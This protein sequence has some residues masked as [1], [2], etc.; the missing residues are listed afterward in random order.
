MIVLR[1]RW[2]ILWVLLAVLP[3]ARATDDLT[4]LNQQL[5]VT[6][7]KPDGAYEI[8]RKEGDRPAIR[9]LVAAQ[10]NHHWVRSNEYPTHRVKQSDFHDALGHGE[11]LTVTLTGLANRPNLLYILRLYD[12]LPFGDIEVQVHNGT[13]KPV[14][15]EAIRSVEAFG[16][17]L[18]NLG[19]QEGS[20]R[21]LSD[22][23]S[24][25]SVQ[26]YDLGQAPRGMH[27]GVGSQLIY[28]RDSRQSL[29]FGA[30]TADRFLTVLR[31]QT[32][33]V[34]DKLRTTSYTIDSTGTTEARSHEGWFHRSPADARI[35]LSLPLAPG[36]SLASE[37]LMFALGSDYH[38]EV[39]SYGAA[40]RHLH[41]A[42]VTG[43]NPMGWWSWSAYYMTLD[44]GSVYTN[45]QWMAQHLRPLGY[46]FL[47]VDAG[48]QYSVS[49]FTTTNAAQFPHGMRQLAA[50]ISRLGLKLAL[51]VAPLEVG[52][53]S[54]V[55][56]NHKD[57]LVRNARGKPIKFPA[58]FDPD[59]EPFFVLDATN[60][61]AQEYLRQTY[62]T[63]AREWGARYIKLDFMEITSVEGYYHRPHTTAL[64]AQKIALQIIRD[65]VGEDV[66]LDKD[67]SPML[68]PV[69]IVDEG[70]IS[71]DAKHSFRESKGNA[72]GIFARYYMNRNFFVNDPDAFTLQREAPTTF[73][74]HEGLSPLSLNEA[75]MSIVLAAIAG[76]MFEIG[77]DLPTLASEPERMALVTNKDLLQMVKLGRASSPLDLMEYSP[78]DLQPSVTFLREDDRQ[79]MLAVFN[80]TEQPRSHAF[81]LADLGL[82]EGHAYRLYDALNQEQPMPFDG[83]TIMLNDQVPHSVRLIKIIDASQPPVPPRIEVEAPTNAKANEM[84]DFSVKSAVDGV[85]PLDC[86][87]DFGDGITAEGARLTHAYTLAGTYPVKLTVDGLDGVPAEK[88]FSITVDGQVTFGPPVRYVEGL[89]RESSSDSRQP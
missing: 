43:P 1:T 4:I 9:S 84:I 88:T 19:A 73:F 82:P 85:L 10:I 56:Q 14:T 2:H 63:L 50:D 89:N 20:E 55:S 13:P 31:L 38:A 37:R 3:V 6:V 22:G 67:G 26:V 75:Q 74:L 52:E 46:D 65:A 54:W 87:W 36:A 57:W 35:E 28:N 80:W 34:Q 76:A 59:K 70:R 5:S 77:D 16:D 64:E 71:G 45:A 30:L 66:L 79:S 47:H 83:K 69:G 42:R 81:D 25:N 23:F 49:E 15:V 17:P 72:P 62:R 60:P 24:E 32:E 33:K 7:R 58:G 27:F 48:Y 40:I 11:E 61:G 78:D 18:L 21:V 68:T 86:H 12:H 44:E 29:F 51:W 53:R 39:E 41:H 8:R